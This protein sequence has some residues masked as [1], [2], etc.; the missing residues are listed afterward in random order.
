VVFNT[1]AHAFPRFQLGKLF[2]TG[3]ERKL[4]DVV[5]KSLSETTSMDAGK[6]SAESGM[7][8]QTLVGTR[9]ADADVALTSPAAPSMVPE[10]FVTRSALVG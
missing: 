5:D 10:G 8:I 7:G 6:T 3:W 4:K 9:T 1:E 2:E